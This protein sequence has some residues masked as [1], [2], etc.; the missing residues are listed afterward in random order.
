ML[1]FSTRWVD[2]LES[3]DV[4]QVVFCD[5]TVAELIKLSDRIVDY[6]LNLLSLLGKEAVRIFWNTELSV[7]ERMFSSGRA[8]PW[9]WSRVR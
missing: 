8:R 1:Q 7:N 6:F 9:P 2:E 5:F 4:H 3:I